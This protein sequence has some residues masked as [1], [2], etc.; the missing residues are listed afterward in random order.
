M[1]DVRIIRDGE[2][3]LVRVV[4]EGPQGPAGPAGVG[5]LAQM[6]DVDITDAVAGS[7]LVYDSATGKWVGSS[8]T[9]VD[10]ILNGGNF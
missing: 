10:E 7:T 3:R 9:A 1:S 2:A 8:D 5:R 4:S 6:T